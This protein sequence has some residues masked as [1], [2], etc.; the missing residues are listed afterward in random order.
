MS[1]LDKI[2]Q[3]AEIEHDNL[4]HPYVGTEH[5]LLALLSYDDELTDKLRENN[6]TYDK[7]KSKLKEIIGEGTKKSMYL[8]YTPMLRKVISKVDNSSD[9]HKS[10]F[11]SLLEVNDGIAICILENMKIKLNKV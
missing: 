4:K 11:D 6:L 1:E 9:I 3:K 8:L 7:F 10:L 2:L 5:L